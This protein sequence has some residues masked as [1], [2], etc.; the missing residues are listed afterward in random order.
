[1]KEIKIKPCK[2]IS[3][4]RWT[5]YTKK[6]FGAIVAKTSA[7][8]GAIIILLAGCKTIYVPVPATTSTTVNVKDS[9]VWNIKDSVRITEKSRYKDYGDLLKTL[10]IDGNRSHMTAWIDTTKNIINGE[11]IED[12]VKEKTRIEYRD[13]YI[14]KDSIQLVEKPIPIEVPVEVKYVP[15]VYKI[16]SAIGLLTRLSVLGFIGFKIYQ[17][18]GKGFLNLIKNIFKK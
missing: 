1:M 18:K 2:A 5:H 3:Q 15:N 9:T 16:L 13:K 7:I 8:C 17:L 10:K 6:R 14:Y 12:P 4:G 11:L